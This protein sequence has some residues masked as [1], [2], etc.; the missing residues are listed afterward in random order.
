MKPNDWYAHM[1][2]KYKEKHGV[3]WR[4]VD[5]FSDHPEASVCYETM[6]RMGVEKRYFGLT[7]Q[8]EDVS[9]ANAIMIR[10]TY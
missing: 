6:M 10:D 3:E 9:I 4:H 7:T 2:K 5:P 8:D 1:R